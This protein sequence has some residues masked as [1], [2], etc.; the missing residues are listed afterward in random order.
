MKYIIL[1]LLFIATFFQA[2]GENTEDPIV[3]VVS[4]IE[5]DPLTEDIYAT[6]STHTL[7]ATITYEDNT[8][9]DGTEGVTW[10]NSNYGLVYMLGGI[11]RP[12]S[13]G[14]DVN[15]S[16]QYE[17]FTNSVE[18]EIISLESFSI[19]LN[20]TNLTTGTH[21]IS[22]PGVFEDNNTKEIQNNIVFDIN[23]SGSITQKDDLT[24]EITLRAG[25]T[26]ITASVFGYDSNESNP[27]GLRPKSKIV[28]IN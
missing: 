2:C 14:G 25:D 27:E 5:I 16:I 15:I 17:G 11:I 13:N 22:F 8:T 4:K 7:T 28:T 9:A 26:N 19:D 12:V 10:E 6:D 24:Y 21:V 23:N 18:L 20:D 1:S 3:P